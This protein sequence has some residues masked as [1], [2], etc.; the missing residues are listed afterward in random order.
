MRDAITSAL[1]STRTVHAACGLSL[2]LGLTFIFVWAPHPWGWAGIDFYHVLAVELARGDAFSTT[3]VPWG[4]AYFVA[5]WYRLVGERLWVPLVA[6]VVANAAVPLLLYHLVVPLAGMRTA[7]LSALIVG[8]FSFNTVYASTQASDAICTVLFMAGLVSFARGCRTKRTM[9]FALAG[10]FAGLAPQFRPNLILLPAVAV[11]WY[12]WQSPRSWRSVR[13][14]GVFLSVILVALA[15]WTIRNYRLTGLVIPTSTHGGEQLWYGSLQ[16]GQHLESRSYNPRRVFEFAAFEYTSLIDT[17]VVISADPI[18]CIGRSR[19]AVELVYWTDRDAEQRRAAP[20]IVRGRLEFEVP[21]QPADTAVYYFFEGAWADTGDRVATPS[22]GA[23]NPYVMFVSRDHL[24]DLDRHDAVLD[25][26]DL[27]RLMRALAWDERL[28]VPG[29]LDLNRDG[30]TTRDDLAAVVGHLLLRPAPVSVQFS[31]SDSRAVLTL[32]DG[33]TLSVPR[34]FGGRQTDLDTDGVLAGTLVA[35]SRSFTGIAARRI[36]SE[37]HLCPAVDNVRVNDVYYRKEPHRLNRYTALA[38]DNISR[39]P[40]NFAL[41]SGYRLFR[42]FIIRGTD[43]IGTAQQFSGSRWAYV[44]G[45][46][47]STAYFVVFIAGIVMAVRQ[48]SAVLG[49]LV[50]ILYVP[51]TLCVVL[52]NM[53]YTV[54]VQPL[55]FV[56]VAVAVVAWMRLDTRRAGSLDPASTPSSRTRR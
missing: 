48:R 40:I 17:S 10:L 3:D 7:V 31:A 1:D 16:V 8:V 47:L 32:P 53:R 12:L 18:D 26:F 22:Q 19:P 37:P 52:T 9:D 25:I 44:A 11:G 39:E 49:L 20:K 34:N 51:L 30:V 14:M 29:L 28:P 45:Q 4:Y 41:A 56:F 24:G 43:D 35:M 5:F 6:Q 21:G 15:P 23:L 42:M 38:F 33:S 36:P 50:P 46:A 13:H 55:M 2:I 27:T 54:T